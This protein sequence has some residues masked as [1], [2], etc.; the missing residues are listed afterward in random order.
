MNVRRLSVPVPAW[1][2]WW[3]LATGLAV[4]LTVAV[5]HESALEIVGQ[6]QHSTVFSHG[7]AAVPVTVWLLWRGRQRIVAEPVSVSGKGLVWLLLCG[8][9]WFA[10]RVV[11]AAVVGHFGML[12]MIYGVI[13]SLVGDRRFRAMAGP[14]SFLVFGVPFGEALIPLLMDW[15]AATVVAGLR[16]SG[17]PVWQEGNNFSIPSGRWSVIEWCSGISYLSVSFFTG[18]VFAYITFTRWTKRALFVLISIALP[19]VANWVRA[20]TIVIVAHLSDNQLGVAVGHTAL[21]WIIFGV[22]VFVVFGL[23]ARWA[24][25]LPVPPMPARREGRTVPNRGGMA[26]AATLVAILVWPAMTYRLTSTDGGPP[27]QR[28]L[29]EAFLDGCE[30]VTD[31]GPLDWPYADAV[32]RIDGI[33]RCDG[34]EVGLL[35]AWYRGQRQ[36][37]ELVSSANRRLVGDRWW[38]KPSRRVHQ[39][40]GKDA[41]HVLEQE[42]QAGQQRVVTRRFYWVAGWITTSDTMAKLLLGAARIL[43]RGDDSAIVLWAQRFERTDENELPHSLGQFGARRVP[44][45][46]AS[47]QGLRRHSRVSATEP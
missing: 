16:L 7:F 11:G 35:V 12:G 10:G 27:P 33:Y 24:D 13:W 9:A 4:L 37:R 2:G 32:H 5:C 43:D 8:A 42:F 14:L 17:I 34:Q 19:I 36:G 41:F 45:L 29:L 23:G 3:W 46:L 38:T 31:G 20:Y 44:P 21:G 47:L 39:P 1:R 18:S 25:P 40:A 15:T 28:N 30:R 26:F 6:W 22:F